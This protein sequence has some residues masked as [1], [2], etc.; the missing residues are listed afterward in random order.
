MMYIANSCAISI[1][2]LFVA[3]IRTWF[4]WWISITFNSFLGQIGK[5][6]YDEIISGKYEHVVE[7]PIITRERP[8]WDDPLV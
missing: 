1:A 5:E 4:S 6:T 3:N 7:G 8:V 2:C